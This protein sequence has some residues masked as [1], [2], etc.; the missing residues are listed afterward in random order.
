MKRLLCFWMAVLLILPSTVT[1]FAEETADASEQETEAVADTVQTEETAASEL[2]LEAS[3]AIGLGAMTEYIADK[4]ATIEDLAAAANA[5]GASSY[6]SDRYFGKAAYGNKVKRVTAEAVMID[7]LGYAIFFDD[8]S[9]DSEDQAQI[10]SIARR[11]SISHNIGCGAEE[12]ITMRDLAVMIYNTLR[13]ASVETTYSPTG[14]RSTVNET[15]YMERVLGMKMVYGIV[16]S[17][18]Y[19]S[20]TGADGTDGNRV[21]IGGTTYYCEEGRYEEFIGMRVA[22]LAKNDGERTQIL[23]MF[24]DG[25]RVLELKPDMLQKEAISKSSIGYWDKNDRARMASLSS[26][27]DVL[28]NYSLYPDYTAD[29]FKLSQGRLILIDNDESGGYD[30]VKIEKYQ[31]FE[32]LSVSMDRETISDRYGNKVNISQMI[33]KD[34]P[35]IE[36]GKRIKAQNIPAQSIAT[37]YTNKDGDAVRLYIDNEKAAGMVQRFDTDKNHVILEDREFTYVEEIKTKIESVPMLSLLTVKLNHY[38][39]IAYFE[40]SGDAVSYGYMIAFAN[41]GSFDEVSVKM[42]TQAGEVSEMK[43]AASVKLN[44]QKMSASDAFSYNLTSG[45]WD[46]AGAIS[47]PV[48]YKRNSKGELTA[49]NTVTDKDDGNKERLRKDKDGVFTYYSNPK[50]ICA[51]VRLR[52]TT[53]VFVVPTDLNDERYFK[54]GSYNVL[55]NDH[56]Y[57]AQ[58]YNVDENYYADCVVVR[59]DPYGAYGFNTINELGGAVYMVHDVR[60]TLGD[61]D[62]MTTLLEVRQ[63]GQAEDTFSEF[64]F[65]NSDIAAT[66]QGRGY[67]VSELEPGD[68]IMAE[69]AL[70]AVGYGGFKILYRADGTEPYEEAKMVW[71]TEQTRDV[72]YSDSNT[73]AAGTIK[74]IVE[75]GCIANFKPT[76]GEYDNWNRLISFNGSLPV[77]I[78]ERG[79]DKRYR[80]S[81]GDLTAGDTVFALMNSGFIKEFIIYR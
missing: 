60:Q 46:E 63:L 23:S 66:F 9:I 32:I 67:K 77:Y 8:G 55:G 62:Q 3:V 40:I 56:D 48:T 64:T 37:C 72:F 17:T 69:T 57:T 73:Y 18:S 6:V 61:E 51:D 58:V 81:V 54:Y 76:T 34:Y 27:V 39:E 30:V 65:V 26:T 47:Q 24:D 79:K 21:V 68:I 36:N 59:V 16:Q 75:D 12:I 41:T 10:E 25:N 22:A 20:I 28:Y 38:G 53:K 44:G 14:N 78:C 15:P 29:D 35:I 42:F 33:E 70:Y 7:I 5:L 43:T 74:Q 45:L 80:G 4:E 1:A 2:T 19:S 50:T 71:Y 31:S 49:I 52:D 11:Y 13:A